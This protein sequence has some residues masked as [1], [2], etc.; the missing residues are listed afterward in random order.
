MNVTKIKS[1][2]W[3]LCLLPLLNACAS[4]SPLFEP[5]G[6]ASF[7]PDKNLPFTE[8]VRDSRENIERVLDEIR[9]DNGERKYLGGYTNA[10]AA[11]MRSPF[12]VPMDENERCSDISKGAGKGFLLIH[13]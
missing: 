6:K 3:L 11:E 12:Q 1:L 2:Y 9:P 8:Y 4:N 10:Q 13:G 7:V 5:T